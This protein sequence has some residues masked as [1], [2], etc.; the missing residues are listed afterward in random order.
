[1]TDYLIYRHGSNSANQSL[2]DKEPVAIVE[3]PSRTAA[4]ETEGDEH[5]RRLA[6]DPS[7]SVYA[8]QWLEAVP[9]SKVRV[10][11]WNYVVGELLGSAIA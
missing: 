8:N 4:I 9:K 3:A 10:T 2:S 11:D 5:V 6:L 1:V 7:V